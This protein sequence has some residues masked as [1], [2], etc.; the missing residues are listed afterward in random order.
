M[1]ASTGVTLRAKS[2]RVCSRGAHNGAAGGG[3]GDYSIGEVS[4][5]YIP[6]LYRLPTIFH[7]GRSA[8]TFTY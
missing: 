7:L 1:S 8:C 2:T 5:G 6:A 3:D 4:G